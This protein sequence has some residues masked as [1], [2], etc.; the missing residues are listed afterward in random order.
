MRKS[1]DLG[2]EGRQGLGSV[3]RSGDR[4]ARP[5]QPAGQPPQRGR[6][7]VNQ[8]HSQGGLAHDGFRWGTL[9]LHSQQ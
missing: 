8:Q 2:V 7:V 1:G 3:A 9:H 4:I 5:L 6:I